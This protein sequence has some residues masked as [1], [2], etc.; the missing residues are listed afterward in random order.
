MKVK[1]FLRKLLSPVFGLILVF[2]LSLAPVFTPA[3]IPANTPTTTE[4]TSEQTDT[5]PDT[6]NNTTKTSSRQIQLLP[7]AYADPVPEDTETTDT[8]NATET[9]D[10][11][12]TDANNTENTE[13]ESTTCYDQI[14]G[15][16]WAICPTTGILATVIDTLYGIIENFLAISPLSTD[17]DS[18]IYRVWQ[19]ARDITNIVFVIFLLIVVWSQLTGLGISNYGIKKTLPRIIVAAILVNLSYLICTLAVDVS[20]ILGVSLKNFFTGIA[21]SAAGSAEAIQFSFLDLFSAV[22]TGGAIAGIAIGLSGGLGHFL[23][24]FIGTVLAGVISVVIGF[25][26]IAMRQAV[27]SILVMISPLAFVCYLLPNTEKWFDKWK[28]ALVGMLVFYPMFAGL[29]GASQLAGW[30]I[31]ASANGDAFFV[32]LGAAVRILPL[33]MAGSLMKMSGTVLGQVSNGLHKLTSPIQKS[34]RG[35]AGSH[36]E[37]HKQRYIANSVMPAAGLR[38][39]MDSRARLRALNTKSNTESRMAQAEITAQRIIGT[40]GDAYDPGNENATVKTKVW[41]RDAKSSMNNTLAA[42]TAALDT[43]HILG[44]FGDFH[45]KTLKDRTLANN[46]GAN[47]LDYTRAELAAVNDS[48]ADIDWLM[49][50]YNSF[51]QLGAGNY[52]HDHYITGAAGALGHMGD[53]TVLGQVISKAAANEAKRRQATSLVYAKYG[54]NKTS[55]RDMLVGYYVNDDGIATEAPDEFGRRKEILVDG[56]PEQSPGEFLKYHPEALKGYD[57]FEMVPDGKG[58]MKKRYYFDAKDQDGKFVTRIYKDD[59]PAMKETFAN[60]DMNIQDPID[61]LYGIL[62]GINE[63]DIKVEGLEGVGLARLSTTLGRAMMSSKFSEK[64]SFAGPMYATSVSNR[65]IKDYVHQ[66]LAR[67][68]NLIKTGKPSK[69][70]TQ[71]FAE[72]E[73]LRMLMNPANWEKMLFNEE[74]LSSYLN[75]NGKVL[76]GT[77]ILRGEDGQILRDENGH[78]ETISVPYEEATHE[79]L[80]NTVIKK[81]LVPASTRFATMMTRVTQ[82]TLDNMKPG[83]AKSWVGLIDSMNEWTDPEYTEQYALLEDPFTPQKTSDVIITSRDLRRRLMDDPNSG[84]NNG[85]NGGNSSN[86]GTPGNAPNLPGGGPIN[87]TSAGAP[88]SGQT[89]G[90]ASSAQIRQR[91]IDAQNNRADRGDTDIIVT[92]EQRAEEEARLRA[93]DEAYMEENRRALGNLDPSESPN[94]QVR[95]S[96]VAAIAIDGEEY[97]TGALEELQDALSYDTTGRLQ[98]VIDDFE[99]FHT[100]NFGATTEEYHEYLNSLLDIYQQF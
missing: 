42:Q 37:M 27:V 51:R 49:G 86:G 79:E 80:K 4:T 2:T 16:G 100:T 25:I 3:N 82:Q 59:G 71:D 63:G 38:R 89:Y 24:M 75:V 65:Y 6:T 14:E 12:G 91:I 22:A 57:K 46:A 34:A 54:Y 87:P 1:T 21:E 67:L 55:A 30:A 77:R 93:I 81:F 50:K 58:G 88:A 85:G 68:D 26:T 90:P 35:W 5:A 10:N 44:N 52:Q 83:V 47:F 9:T 95:I 43:S 69:F 39:Y 70:N 92:E 40:G 13:E 73:Q 15:L 11:T 23:W 53:N 62:S 17:S 45:N 61:G 19:Y 7:S 94:I 72:L 32:I 28:N 96:E 84:N 20:N 97:Y 99:Q 8:N 64:A 76:E 98:D 18:P 74:S 29:F 78:V 36:A 31:M 48:Y 33:F 56:K 41:A 60:Y 66:N